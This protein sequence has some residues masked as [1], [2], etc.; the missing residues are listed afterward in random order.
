MGILDQVGG[1]F[2][3][4]SPNQLNEQFQQMMQEADHRDIAHGI[5]QAF[6]SHETPPFEDLVKSLFQHS[7][8]HQKAGILQ[9]LASSVAPTV[10]QRFIGGASSSQ[11]A[12]NMTPEQ[13]KNVPPEAVKELAAHAAKENPSMIDKISEFYAQHPQLV[14]A[15]GTS[16]VGM[17]ISK[18]GAKKEGV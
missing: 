17:I 1:L 6:Q 4:D 16:V 2:G 12:G 10:V 11:L 18:M 3:S 7:N 13:M 14:Q 15:L 9:L 5:S 8:D